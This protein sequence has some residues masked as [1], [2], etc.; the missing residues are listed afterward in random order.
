MNRTQQ[1]WQGKKV[2][3]ALKVAFNNVSRTVLSR[4]LG[5]IGIEPDLVMGRLF[6]E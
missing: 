3:G 1:A 5:E 2:A 6:H 4:R